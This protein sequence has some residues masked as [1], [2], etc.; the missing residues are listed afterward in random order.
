MLIKTLSKRQKGLLFER[1]GMLLENGMSPPEIFSS[2][3]DEFKKISD[4]LLVCLSKVNSGESIIESLNG[5]GLLTRSEYAT[6]SAG[7]QSGKLP[8][9]FASLTDYIES[10]DQ[11][12]STAKKAI[13]PNIGY[14]ILSIA[15]LYGMLISI[16][17]SI[18][19]NIKPVKRQQFFVFN[20]SDVTMHF[21]TNY[22]I[23]V[24]AAAVLLVLYITQKLNTQ[25]GRDLLMDS[26]LK[27]P[28]LKQG[29]L[30]FSLAMWARQTSMMMSAG[31]SFND[32]LAL[33]ANTL[34]SAIR[35]GMN[36]ILTDVS[37]QGWSFALN[38]KNWPE[39]DFRRE[40]PPELFG[41]LAAGGSTGNLEKTLG[42]LSI[43]LERTSK[44]LIDISTKIVSLLA[45]FMAI[46]S[47][48][49]VM[50]SV[51]TASL[52]GIAK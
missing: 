49:F 47:V 11:Q 6:L 23:Y 44:R 2:L 40:W 8:Q 27:V 50:I 15:I 29:V 24:L 26:M 13:L 41:A 38:K 14:V 7:E 46:G 9:T 43:S 33:T 4:K 16:I 3:S 32:V 30:T 48:G 5:V 34:P 28:I 21:H 1:I 52:S 10:I 39:K 19:Q 36:T 42:R 17:P 37:I 31:V 35:K 18:A 25:E 20:L 45:F 12:V 22:A 51:V